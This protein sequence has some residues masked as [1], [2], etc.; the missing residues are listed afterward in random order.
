MMR[1]LDERVASLEANILEVKQF[2]GEM[3]S[4]IAWLKKLLYLV[5]SLSAASVA[6]FHLIDSIFLIH[7]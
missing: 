6:G 1:S 3:K 4:D 5:L 2:H 7:P